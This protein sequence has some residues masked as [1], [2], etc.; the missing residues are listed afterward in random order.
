MKKKTGLI[1][2]AIIL[3]LPFLFCGCVADLKT[4]GK[5]ENYA[6]YLS[7][8]YIYYKPPQEDTEDPGGSDAPSEP[9]PDLPQLDGFVALYRTDFDYASP[10][11][12]EYAFVKMDGHNLLVSLHGEA[13]ECSEDLENVEVLFDKYV[14][15][16]NGRYGVKS[17]LGDLLLSAEYESVQICGETIAA[18]RDLGAVEVYSSC[19]LIGTFSF[20]VLLVAEEYLLGESGLHRADGT[21]VFCEDYRMIFAPSEGLGVIYGKGLFGYGNENGEVVVPPSYIFVSDFYCGFAAVTTEDFRQA[22]IDTEG[23]EVISYDGAD[24]TFLS[25]D[26]KCLIYSQD[27][28]FHV[29]DANM[30]DVTP[31]M[32]DN[33]SG[34]RVYNG[35]LITDDG[36]RVY[37]LW[38][39]KFLPYDFAS[40]AV[41]DDII[42]GEYN[43]G[44]VGAFNMDFEPILRRAESAD[45]EYGV[46]TFCLD[47]K[48]YLYMR[49]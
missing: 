14:F 20:S 5:I 16:D 7:K 1:I 45:Y 10:F 3:A 22:I 42:I 33:I 29:A 28:L 47:G 30:N 27:T 2:I 48:Y 18:T 37:S 25:Y 39:N 17:V 43:G 4:V 36:T 49:G 40:V 24:K 38:E 15:S 35:Y 19:A 31:R 26:G 12:G 21:A 8:L 6:D 44:G 11:F 13:M 41:K 32:F 46:L 34:N 9:D 23:N